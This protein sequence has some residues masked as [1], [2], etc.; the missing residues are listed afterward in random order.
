M[1]ATSS[2]SSSSRTSADEKRLRHPSLLKDGAAPHRASQVARRRQ[3]PGAHASGAAGRAEAAR[4]SVVSAGEVSRQSARPVTSRGFKFQELATDEAAH[5]PIRSPPPAVVV[6]AAL[7]IREGACTAAVR[8]SETLP[9]SETISRWR[10]RNSSR[11]CVLV[12]VREARLLHGADGQHWRADVVVF[13]HREIR[14]EPTPRQ[15]RQ[16]V[17]HRPTQPPIALRS[18]TAR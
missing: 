9:M 5:A 13:E 17:C 1:R 18:L 4:Q 8:R 10:S 2:P 12:V 16:D 6:H 14:R 3:R 11:P 15:A 7:L